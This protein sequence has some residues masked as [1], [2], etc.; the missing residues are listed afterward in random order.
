MQ[1]LAIIISTALLTISTAL[2]AQDDSCDS[3]MDI[4][5][6]DTPAMLDKLQVNIR[7]ETEEHINLA[8]QAQ[9]DGNEEQC[10]YH[11][12]KALENIR[13]AGAFDELDIDH[14]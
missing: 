7:T 6:T 9:A 4:L 14:R 2:Y 10:L 11:S 3:N 1:A 5:L 8:K 12:N 13:E